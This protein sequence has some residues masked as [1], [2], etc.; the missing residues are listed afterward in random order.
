MRA[1]SDG[2][3]ERVW[4]R[5][6]LVHLSVWLSSDDTC[7]SSLLTLGTPW[8]W[9]SP[10]WAEGNTLLLSWLYCIMRGINI[11]WPEKWLVRGTIIAT[12]S[13]HNEYFRQPAK[14]G[15]MSVNWYPINVFSGGRGPVV[16]FRQRADHE[17]WWSHWHP[18][19]N[20]PYALVGCTVW[21]SVW[22]VSCTYVMD[23]ISSKTSLQ[24]FLFR[25]W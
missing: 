7:L 8:G 12:V 5:Y 1:A 25:L 9:N 15:E 11:W 17:T 18:V 21:T 4:G 14:W 19:S 20:R 24:C 3:K 16:V 23:A 22:Y 13:G 2:C 10:P 6:S